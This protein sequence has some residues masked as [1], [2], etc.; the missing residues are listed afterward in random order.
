VDSLQIAIKRLQ[1]DIESR[2]VY[3]A[4]WDNSRDLPEGHGC[5]CL[6]SLFFRYFDDKLTLTATFRTHNA[7]DAWLENVYGLMAIQCYVAEAVNIPRGP[8]TVFSHSISISTE[9]L[10]R[11]KAV[12]DKKETD[13]IINLQ[14]GKRD[15]RYDHHGHFTVTIDRDTQEIVVQHNHE[16][17]LLTEYRGKTAQILEKQL[18]RD[19]AISEM[20]H[21]LYL[22]REIA[23]KEYLLKNEHT[24]IRDDI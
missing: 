19:D 2:H 3:I 6:V 16:G 15:P 11:A 5:P 13:E 22:G 1:K 21:A 8:I 10:E 24:K 9:V 7:M 23:K 14:T 20:S 4:L 12:A 17:I 18:A